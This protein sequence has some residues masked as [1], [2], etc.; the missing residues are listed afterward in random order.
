MS[1]GRITYTQQIVEKLIPDLALFEKQLRTNKD[2]DPKPKVVMD[3][4]KYN[5]ERYWKALDLATRN[6]DDYNAQKARAFYMNFM[7][8]WNGSA[9]NW[10]NCA[11]QVNE[12]LKCVREYHRTR[13][14]GH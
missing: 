10:E 13:W 2:T 14:G 3:D 9:G 7:N 4:I 1:G 5:I 8:E 11:F 12:A 6:R